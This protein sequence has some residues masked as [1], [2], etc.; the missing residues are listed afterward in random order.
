MQTTDI[1]CPSHLFE[2]TARTRPNDIAVICGSEQLTYL[3]LDRRANQLAHLLLQR[4][5][6]PDA[7][8]GILLERSLETYVA[9]LAVLKAGATF[10]PLDP[11]LPADRVAYIAADAELG[12]LLTTSSLRER[13][14]ALPCSVLEL[15]R[16]ARTVAGQPATRPP[17]DAG[18]SSLCYI[19]YTSGTTGRP[20]GVAVSRASIVNFLDVVTPI[21][22]VRSDDR[23]YQGMTLAFDFSFEEIWPTWIAG[24][25]LVA[26][27]TDSRRLGHGLTEFLIQQRITVLCCVPTLL[28][29]IDEDVP[30]LRALLVG[31]EACPADLV[32]RWSRPG[33]RML[34][35]YGP[36]EATV[37]ATWC[38]LVP[39]R[40]VTIGRPLPTYRVHILDEEL[41]P[42]DAGQ[43]GEICIGGPGVAVG[44]LHR[45]DLTRDRFVANPIASERAEAP[46]LY[47]T[48]DLGRLTPAGE[49]EYLGRIDT[50]VKIRGYRIELSE[51]EA[52]I[53]RDAALENA[54]V[55]ALERD[56]VVEELVAYVTLRDGGDGAADPDL[57]ERLHASLQD[58]LPAYMVPSYIEVLDR[59]PL[60]AADKV[61]RA[62]LPAPTS[63]RLGARSTAYVAP[64]TPL[65]HEL[66]AVWAQ[67]MGR[68]RIS[69]EDDFFTDLGGHSLLAACAVSQLR[70]HRG[71]ET[72]AIGDLYAEPT[73][74]GLA[75][76]I[77][78]DRFAAPADSR[79]EA[80]TRPR[81]L[82]SNRRVMACGL[83]QIGALYGWMQLLTLPVIGVLYAALQLLHEPV[84]ELLT[85]GGPANH[86]SGGAV[87]GIVSAG[88]FS[89]AFTVVLLPVAGSR[90]LMR[91]VRP[92]CYPL[93]GVTYARWW[94]QGKFL[95]LS[96][97]ALLSGSPLAAPYLRLLGARIGRGCHLATGSVIG[98]PM[99]VELGDGV[100]LGYGARLLPHVVEGG[101]L[102]LAPVRI[103]ADSFIGT[104]SI[105]LAGG[106]VGCRTTIG[107]QSLVPAGHAIGDDEHWAGSPLRRR[108]SAPPLLQAMDAEA[109]DRRWPP[110]VL[111]GFVLGAALLMLLPLLMMAPS[112]TLVGIVAVHAG[113]AWAAAST[114]LAAPLFVLVVLTV[115]I[116]GKRAV[117]P[118]ARPGIHH[119]RSAFGLRKWLSDHMISEINLVRTIY[120]TLYLKPVLRLLGARI[121][122]WAEVS[123]INFVDPDMLTLGDES[124]VAGETV[125]AP[126]VFHRG[127]IALGPARVGR[128]SFVGNGAILPGFCEMG[129]N[130]LLGLHSVPPTSS[131]EAGSTWLG[132]HA[133]RLPRRQTSQAFPEDLTFRPR[134][135]LVAW[136][137]GIEYLRLT[138]PATIAE[139]S[140]LL[141]VYLTIRL[142]GV[143][144]PAALLALFP[145]LAFGAGM[146]CYLAVVALKWIVIGRYRPRVEPMWNVWVRRTELITG[147]YSTLA[148]PLFN[149]FLTGT[150]WAGPLLRLL[151]ARIGR[152]VWLATIAFSE[153]DLVEL[154]DDA[155]MSEEAAL[156]THL[157]E[158]RVMKMS[159]V[160]VGAGS[161][162][163]AVSVV[164]YDAEVGAGATVE[165]QTLVM[166]G[167]SLP[168]GSRWRGIPARAVAEGT[169]GISTASAA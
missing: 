93:W 140:M 123:T 79:P 4:G 81:L 48:G 5:A 65:E 68:D 84:R 6:G 115:G 104:N 96:P 9:L 22:C 163:G 70:R 167:E 71:L 32:R 88:A 94:L 41:G 19:I 26:G 154:G 129:D 97:V 162:L 31:G 10:V 146:A 110:A 164:L 157:Y 21:Y 126:A 16:A 127:C 58:R 35:T 87:I 152:R 77:S 106:E 169:V 114:L 111:A 13:T 75:Q 1:G 18:A 153:F 56:G 53:R 118:V 121:G 64:R 15:D 86:L 125:V 143:L 72:L 147:L 73:I 161:S 124:F 20:K 42:V 160:R 158:D 135:H 2:Q 95:A 8:V 40:P 156:Q 27:P 55:T 113:L 28:A 155:A 69:V 47:R 98:M 29:T 149:G 14:E 37:T 120:D 112:A 108:A 76:H 144:S 78:R 102:H 36:T 44:Y 60:L 7:R 50:Q 80:A 45:A 62:R 109:D 46:R 52:V 67:V 103:G 25:T 57:R 165:A 43:T 33:R 34:N 166:K 168:A 99:L 38:E 12:D 23:V 133:I 148:G 134:P 151:G 145:V 63:P 138:L 74:R 128:R 83:A 49:I 142:A 3:E 105:V 131:L 137:L 117:M 51:I 85:A 141:D 17:N 116:V 59:F 91:G 130:S 61:D 100:S 11:A 89:L 54:V 139:L 92:G 119:E 39:D 132:S 107:E 30:S 136:R 66:A 82:H 24:A 90:L 122:R 159:R 150:P 101:R